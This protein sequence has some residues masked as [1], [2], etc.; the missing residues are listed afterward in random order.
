MHAKD[1]ACD[2]IR[3]GKKLNLQVPAFQISIN[4]LIPRMGPVVYQVNDGSAVN[5][6]VYFLTATA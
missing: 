5:H 1:L 3:H 4:I 2:E 6:E